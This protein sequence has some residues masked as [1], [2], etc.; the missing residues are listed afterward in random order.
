VVGGLRRAVIGIALTLCAWAALPQAAQ[1]ATPTSPVVA[2][3]FAGTAADGTAL[4]LGVQVTY[5]TLSRFSP[6]DPTASP[7]GPGSDFLNLVMET[8][9]SAGTAPSFNG[10][11]SVPIGDIS[12]VL[13]GGT[14]VPALPPG[15]QLGFLEGNYSFVV[16]ATTTG[17]TLEVTGVTVSAIE[18]PGAVGNG[19]AI[20]S[21]AF[22]PARTS[23]VVPPPAAV[24]VPTSTDPTTTAPVIAR[25][26]ATTHRRVH[27]TRR[28]P[29][30]GLTT[31]QT[32]GAGTGGGIVVLVFVIPLWRRRAFRRADRQ[33]RVIFDAPPVLTGGP[34]PTA[35]PTP[36]TDGPPPEA[37]SPG[38][39]VEVRVLG[40][41]IIDGLVRPISRGP[42]TELLAFL[43]L[44]PG[45]SFT[46]D[47]LRS[48]IWTDGRTEPKADTLYTYVSALRRSLPPGALVKSGTRFT[49]TEAVTSDWSRFCTLVEAHDDRAERLGGALDLV[50]GPPFAGALSGRNAPYA[51]ATDLAHQMEVAVEKAGHELAVLFLDLGNPVPADAVI[52]QV[53]RCVPA[54]IVARE[55]SL[56][57]GSLLGGPREV[58][59]RLGV[60]RH[61]MG[62]DAGLLEPLARQLAE[63]G[64]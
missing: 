11:D 35:E 57:V 54:S 37:A 32:V 53:L 40:P 14:T 55:D 9:P 27:A 22:Q 10:F 48:A 46:T 44:H 16:P 23:V 18:Y 36:P 31:A 64:S 17:G 12:L 25:A 43:A 60:A 5:V 1:A 20:T 45:Q 28:T 29:A 63:S 49:L 3:S 50:R 8:A 59:R 33:G 51:W 41:V 61:A 56:R 24:T 58:D 30:T 34:G 47:E 21:I 39:R 15:P 4:E 7:G 52:G 2:M 62:D 38:V 42:V 6:G 26:P 13:A 19:G